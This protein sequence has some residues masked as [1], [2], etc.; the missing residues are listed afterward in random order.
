MRIIP[1]A[2]CVT[3]WKGEQKEQYVSYVKVLKSEPYVPFYG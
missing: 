2:L 1:Y 3:L